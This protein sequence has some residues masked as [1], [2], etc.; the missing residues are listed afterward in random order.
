MLSGMDS[1]GKLQTEFGRILRNV[2][3]ER[4]LSQE[5]LALESGLDQT[6]ISLLERGER[7]PTLTSLFQ[8]C[9]ALKLDP[10]DVVRELR[11]KLAAKK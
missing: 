2:R 9:E 5:Q 3:N 11:V 7:Q 10:D 8:L 6:F 4:G 1:G